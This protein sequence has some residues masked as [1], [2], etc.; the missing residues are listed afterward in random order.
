MV[1]MGTT[2]FTFFAALEKFLLEDGML[3][4]V[5][6]RDNGYF[7]FKVGVQSGNYTIKIVHH[8]G[9]FICSATQSRRS[10]F[11]CYYENVYDDMWI[12]LTSAASDQI[13]LPGIQGLTLEANV[14]SSNTSFAIYNDV[15]ELSQGQEM[16]FWY[17]EDLLKS[18]TDDNLGVVKFYAYAL[19]Q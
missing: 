13:L 6:P 9:Y 11:G 5:K 2:T 12:V 15:I 19:K 18:N 7:Q 16:R 3:A 8:S 14:L 10:T 4:E 17:K 1:H